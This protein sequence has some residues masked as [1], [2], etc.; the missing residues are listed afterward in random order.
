MMMTNFGNL[1][2]V[3]S[4]PIFE[5]WFEACWNLQKM[6]LPKEFD[7]EFSKAMNIFQFTLLNRYY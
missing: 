3:Y 6:S 7:S 5:R 4:F 1:P 2:A